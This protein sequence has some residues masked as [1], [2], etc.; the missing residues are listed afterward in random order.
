MIWTNYPITSSNEK[1]EKEKTCEAWKEGELPGGEV[2]AG[3]GSEVKLGAKG[4]AERLD[5]TIE[6][7]YF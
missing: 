2:W 4:G 7:G 5:L 6:E 3:R 1:T